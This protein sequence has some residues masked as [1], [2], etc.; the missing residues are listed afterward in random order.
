VYDIPMENIPANNNEDPLLVDLGQILFGEILGSLYKF[1]SEYTWKDRISNAEQT[2]KECDWTDLLLKIFEYG[3]KYVLSKFQYRIR[4][5]SD[6][7]WIL[8]S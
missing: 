2:V 8:M 3:N 4:I 5:H 7:P 1:A 6:S